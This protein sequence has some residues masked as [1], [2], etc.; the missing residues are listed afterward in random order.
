MAEYR[1]FIDTIKQ[2]D[3]GGFN[4]IEYADGGQE[5][6]LSFRALL[7]WVSENANLY[8]NEEEII[9]VDWESNKP[10]FLYSTSVSCNLQTCYIR[11]NYLRTTPGTVS[12]VVSEFNG[13]DSF[14]GPTAQRYEDLKDTLKKNAD[15]VDNP[16]LY[17]TVGNINNIYINIA[18]LSSE[19]FESTKERSDSS[20]SIRQYLQNICDK[21]NKAL[22][23]INDLQVI[24]DVDGTVE[25]LTIVDYQQKRIKGLTKDIEPVE[26]KAQGLGSMLTGI[27]AESSITPEI[28]TMISVGAQAQG[29]AV[30]VEAT[31]FSRLSEGLKDRIY[32]TKGIGEKGKQGNVK[33]EQVETKF[34]N[35]VESYAEL[36]RN[37]TPVAGDVF[38]PVLLQTTDKTNIENIAVELYKSALAKFT[39]SGQ[40]STAFIPIKL[41]FSLYG[42]SGMKIFQKFKLSND[43]L[44]LSYK[45]NFEFIVTGLSHTIDNSKWETSVS[46]LI[47]LK[48]KPLKDKIVRIPITIILPDLTPKT[49]NS[50]PAIKGT[51]FGQPFQSPTSYVSYADSINS[52]TRNQPLQ[53]RL[54]NIIDQA[55]NETGLF[56]EIFSAGQDPPFGANPRRIG[57]R[58][59]D[60][61]YAADIRLKTSLVPTQYLNT[62]DGNEKVTEF[63]E[64]LLKYGIHSIGAGKGYMNNIALHVDISIGQPE[65]PYA[66]YFGGKNATR[67]DAAKWLT[68]LMKGVDAKY[69]VQS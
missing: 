38:G 42:M 10:M 22:G 32:P 31:S 48:D 62:N 56:V 3:F 60:N 51:T 46:S 4:A 43:V 18:L 20:I 15:V 58:R 9:K 6:Y 13:I 21:V 14:S 61:G 35:A 34:S 25:T 63:A 45:G 8:S 33:Q 66:R 69:P 2:P 30:G 47:S 64:A 37:Q 27:K 12:T 57:S 40:T 52:Q 5:V 24:S 36:V 41:D 65:V 55:A 28:A 1:E 16:S 54:F 53:D 67:D 19:I 50:G 68:E 49:N 7:K 17:P 44:P 59:H 11:N 39:D 29:E 23:S 26:I